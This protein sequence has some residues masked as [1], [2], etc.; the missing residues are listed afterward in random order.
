MLNSKVEQ[1][2]NE[3]L[4]FEFYS[5]YLYLSMSMHFEAEGL[6]GIANWFNVQYQEELTHTTVFMKYINLRGG[7][8]E[9]KPIAGVPT[10]WASPIEAF[11]A[12]LEHERE[13]SKR[14]NAL[15]ALAEEEKDYASRDRLMWFVTEQTEEEDSCRLLIDKLNLIGDNGTGLYMFDRELA[16]RT[17]VKPEIAE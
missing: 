7:R 1:A 9:L 10:S 14:I 15:F 8:V 5:A 11:K 17:F 3:Q 2:L 13:V 12:T 16:S 6:Q 4:N